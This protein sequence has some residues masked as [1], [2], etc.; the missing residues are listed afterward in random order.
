[1][2]ITPQTFI[3]S[4]HHFFHSN[5]EKYAQR[6]PDHMEQLVKRHNKVITDNDKVVF[7]G[8]LTFARKEKTIEMVGRMKGEKYLILGNHDH[9]S[10]GWY[11]SLGFKVTEPIYKVFANSGGTY[12]VLL[13]HEPVPCLPDNWYNI[14]GHIH[15]GLATEFGLTK[16][17]FNVSCEVLDYTPKPIF[18]ILAIWKEQRRLE[19]K[20]KEWEA[21]MTP[22]YSGMS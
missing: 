18:E 20:E 6:P 4:D 22:P 16:R 7:L 11:E 13:T 10:V 2:K 14:H 17:H 12:P 15:R 21:K 19:E 1:M 9:H 3:I 5:I 8:D